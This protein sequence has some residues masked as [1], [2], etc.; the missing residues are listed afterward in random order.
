[1]TSLL[2]SSDPCPETAGA[3]VRDLR[4]DRHDALVLVGRIANP[5]KTI[6]QRGGTSGQD[7]EVLLW[8]LPFLAHS[9]FAERRGAEEEW[10]VVGSELIA[11]TRVRA[12]ISSR[13]R[14]GPITS[15]ALF[16]L[17]A[18][19]KEQT[20][21]YRRL[22]MR[23]TW[24]TR[25][26]VCEIVHS[27]ASDVCA[28]VAF[29]TVCDSLMELPKASPTAWHATVPALPPLRLSSKLLTIYALIFKQNER[30]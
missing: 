4:N 7:A 3:R 2:L 25:D 28:C 16:R 13:L 17:G 30:A 9:Y 21:L 20:K 24:R 15:G 27:C 29:R 23:G 11:R 8:C 19:E 22:L 10:R 18:S 1:M 12:A 5:V 26:V 6:A 14:R